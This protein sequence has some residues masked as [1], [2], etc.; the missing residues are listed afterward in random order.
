MSSPSKEAN[1]S[2]Q[3]NKKKEEEKVEAKPETPEQKGFRG[4]PPSPPS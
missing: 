4:T 2:T 1:A 3:S